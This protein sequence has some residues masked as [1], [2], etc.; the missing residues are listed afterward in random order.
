MDVSVNPRGVDLS[1]HNLDDH[2][3]IDWDDF[4]KYYSFAI[5]RAGYKKSKDSDFDEIYYGGKEAGVPMG[6]YHYFR[7]ASAVSTKQQA[8]AFYEWVKDSPPDIGWWMDNE[9]RSGASGV[10]KSTRQDW[11]QKYLLNLEGKTGEPAGI[12]TSAGFWDSY[13]A[14]SPGN[15]DIPRLM[16]PARPRPLWVANWFAEKPR[17]PWDWSVRFGD[18]CWRFWQ[19]TNRENGEPFGIPDSTIDGDWFNGTYAEFNA[20]FGTDIS[21]PGEVP[22]P[23]PQPDPDTTLIEIA[24]LGTGSTLNVR[25]SPWGR[26]KTKTWNGERFRVKATSGYDENPEKYW[27]KIA[28]DPNVSDP[29]ADLWV[30]SWY[31]KPV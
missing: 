21:A 13:I 5:V 7:Y 9:D 4:K 10:T 30:A 27:V 15:T 20:L 6:A 1:T 22:G 23:V 11:T 24:F 31:T 26:V 25:A 18:E 17:L 8:L 28:G 3:D 14:I 16:N 12:Y 19:D 29:Y 2:D